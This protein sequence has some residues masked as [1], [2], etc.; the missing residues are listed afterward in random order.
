MYK[1]IG[2]S[3]LA[4]Y[5]VSKLLSNREDGSLATRASATPVGNTI[6][7][8]FL[9]STTNDDPE[10]TY[11]IVMEV[12][13][14]TVDTFL[15]VVIE[16][17]VG[18]TKEVL[19]FRIFNPITTDPQYSRPS[20]LKNYL[21]A[22]NLLNVKNRFAVFGYAISTWRYPKLREAPKTSSMTSN[23]A[24]PSNQPLPDVSKPPILLKGKKELTLN[25]KNVKRRLNLQGQYD[26][27]FGLKKA[28]D[29]TAKFY[30]LTQNEM[31]NGMVVPFLNPGVHDF[32]IARTQKKIFYNMFPPALLFTGGSRRGRISKGNNSTPWFPWA[33]HLYE[34]PRNQ[35]NIFNELSL[36]GKTRK[37]GSIPVMFGSMAVG[38]MRKVD[39]KSTF[40][41]GTDGKTLLMSIW[42]PN[43]QRKTAQVW[44]TSYLREMFKSSHLW[45]GIP[46]QSSGHSGDGSPR[47]PGAISFN[48]TLPKFPGKK[49]TFFMSNIDSHWNTMN[50]FQTVGQTAPFEIY[51]SRND[52]HITGKTLEVAI[53]HRRK[54]EP[55]EIVE[56]EIKKVIETIKSHIVDSSIYLE[57][58][59]NGIRSGTQD[60][61]EISLIFKGDNKSCRVD[62]FGADHFNS[63]SGSGS[64]VTKLLTNITTFSE[65]KGPVTALGIPLEKVQSFVNKELIS[66]LYSPSKAT[67][68]FTV[69]GNTYGNPP[70][71]NVQMF[72]NKYVF[73]MIKLLQGAKIA[74]ETISMQIPRNSIN[75]PLNLFIE[76]QQSNNQKIPSLLY[77]VM[78]LKYKEDVGTK[79]M[80]FERY[81]GPILSWKP[82]VVGVWN[83]KLQ[84]KTLKAYEK[85]HP[86]G[87]RLGVNIL[88]NYDSLKIREK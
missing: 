10:R 25:F 53:K 35:T 36:W 47:T 54:Y 57:L 8:Q 81:L 79:P 2:T 51:F 7:K 86:I 78:P 58:F 27:R 30:L 28:P 56:I 46:S 34:I 18:N 41:C 50:S 85:S 76:S 4:G 33:P 64:R 11:F 71:L 63:P 13:E 70:F 73:Q 52:G 3:M 15:A 26:N 20:D 83:G 39:D 87:I 45:R 68:Y 77:I 6:I 80:G 60:D 37:R 12:N 59:Q 75:S 74:T 29:F 5:L 55:K 65:N 43:I 67:C 84:D 38:P 82:I 49:S 31:K 42:F 24:T 21:K 23:S 61:H 69:R 62:I 17:T 66:S 32:N 16:T 22:F 72:Q 88:K 1:E 9:R 48:I 40:M 19:L 14:E 44:I